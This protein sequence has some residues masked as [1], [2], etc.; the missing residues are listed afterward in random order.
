MHEHREHTPLSPLSPEDASLGR[1]RWIVAA[2]LAGL[3]LVG[4]AFQLGA[5]KLRAGDKPLQP[6]AAAASNRS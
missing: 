5:A 1:L 4:A 2:A 6:A 3:I